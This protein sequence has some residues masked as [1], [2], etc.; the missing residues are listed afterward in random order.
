[1]SS[2]N[3][4]WQLP[5]VGYAESGTTVSVSEPTIKDQPVTGFVMD[6]TDRLM[7]FVEDVTVHCIQ[8]RFPG[9]VALAEIPLSQRVGELPVRFLPTLAKGGMPLWQIVYHASTFD[10]A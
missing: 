1:V 9:G 2:A 3:D 6:M 10:A 7:C 5:R 8:L 4:N